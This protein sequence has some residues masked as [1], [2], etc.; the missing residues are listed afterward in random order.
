MKYLGFHL[1]QKIMLL[2]KLL[3]D[4][5]IIIRL[6]IHQLVV[7]KLDHLTQVILMVSMVYLLKDMIPLKVLTKV[8]WLVQC[9]SMLE[10]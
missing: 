5:L 4:L 10:L 8:L 6:V 7:L 3:V 2:L 9:S 1:Q